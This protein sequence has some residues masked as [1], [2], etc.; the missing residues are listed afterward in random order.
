MAA[1]T[2][3]DAHNPG[4]GTPLDE[5]LRLAA[6]IKQGTV[7]GTP[8]ISGRKRCDDLHDERVYASVLEALVFT[9]PRLEYARDDRG[10]DH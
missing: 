1:C 3:A 2:R 9:N 8:D 10:H 4:E 6:S 7:A 5:I